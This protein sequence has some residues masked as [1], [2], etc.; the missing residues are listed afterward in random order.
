[1]NRKQ[2]SD[3]SKADLLEN[4]IWEYCME[5][6]IEYVSASNKTEV[7]EGG[8]TA[9]IVATDFIFNNKSKHIGFCSPQDDGELSNIQPVVF[10]G[11][12]QVEFYKDNDWT[13]TEKNKALVGLGLNFHDV[14]PLV[15][16]TR[17]KYDRK[18]FSGTLT[19]F[20][21]QE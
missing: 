14:F 5:N 12:G 9:H 13:E 3:L 11:K 7:N 8:N 16:T 6:K 18:L 2:L 4:Q 1:M 17:V 15:Y 19:D 10:Y 20:N 21:E